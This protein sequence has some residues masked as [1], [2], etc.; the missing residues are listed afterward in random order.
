[1]ACLDMTWQ[2]TC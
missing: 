1:M 2:T